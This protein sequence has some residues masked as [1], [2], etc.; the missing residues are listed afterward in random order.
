MHGRDSLLAPAV[1]FVF[2]VIRTVQSLPF[3]GEIY[4][5]EKRKIKSAVVYRDNLISNID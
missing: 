2:S 3:P 5:E 4:K 1:L